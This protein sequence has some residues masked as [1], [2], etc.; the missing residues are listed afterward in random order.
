[1]KGYYKNN[2]FWATRIMKPF[3]SKVSVKKVIEILIFWSHL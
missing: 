2:D 1:M 3:T